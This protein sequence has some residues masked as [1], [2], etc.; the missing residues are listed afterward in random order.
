[1]ENFSRMLDSS[2]LSIECRRCGIAETDDYEVL[3]ANTVHSMRCPSCGT[4]MHFAIFECLACGSETFFPWANK[5]A[6]EELRKLVCAGCEGSYFD[7][8]VDGRSFA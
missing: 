7:G 8:G 2:P 1:M 3:Q 5:P 6:A 4:D